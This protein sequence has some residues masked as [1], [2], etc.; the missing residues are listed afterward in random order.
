MTLRNINKANILALLDAGDIY[1]GREEVMY[2]LVTLQGVSNGVIL[3]GG[4]AL[5]QKVESWGLY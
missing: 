3:S 4:S 2:A 1:Q 5:G